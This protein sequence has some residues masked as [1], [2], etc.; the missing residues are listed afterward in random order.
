MTPAWVQRR[1]E[2]LS[3]CL[4]SPDVFHQMVERLGEFVVPY[5]HALETETGQHHMHLYLPNPATASVRWCPSI[6]WMKYAQCA[7]APCQLLMHGIRSTSGLRCGM[8]HPPLSSGDG[9]RRCVR[10]KAEIPSRDAGSGSRSCDSRGLSVVRV[11]DRPSSGSPVTPAMA[12]GM[13]DSVWTLAALLA[14]LV[15]PVSDQRYCVALSSTLS[16]NTT[17]RFAP[18]MYEDSGPATNATS[19]ATSSTCPKRSSAVAAFCGTAHSV[20]AGFNSPSVGPPRTLLT[21]NPPPPTPPDIPP[22]K[23]FSAPP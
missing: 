21:A 23:I 20:V 3:D 9:V 13:M 17:V 11:L 15:R 19:A 6:A 2:M 14:R 12:V 4:V 18:V 8:R 5:Q 7:P 1:E 10:R 16:R 22:G